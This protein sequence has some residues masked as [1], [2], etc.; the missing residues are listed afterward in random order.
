MPLTDPIVW[1]ERHA[2]QMASSDE[3]LPPEYLH[4]WLE[5]L[6]STDLTVVVRI[7]ARVGTHDT[8][9]GSRVA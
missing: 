6:L 7:R 3:A 1:H 9:G 5:G 8:R 2:T 4:S